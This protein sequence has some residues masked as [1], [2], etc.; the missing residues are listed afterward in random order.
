MI[1]NIKI[2]GIDKEEFTFLLILSKVSFFTNLVTICLPYNL[3][4]KNARQVPLIK[5][6]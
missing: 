5:P 4:I 2:F 1:D 3:A 6:K